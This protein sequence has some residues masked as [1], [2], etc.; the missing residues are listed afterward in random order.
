LFVCLFVFIHFFL[1]VFLF[2]LFKRWTPSRI[3]LGALNRRPR[4]LLLANIIE[5]WITVTFRLRCSDSMRNF[6]VTD[7]VQNPGTKLKW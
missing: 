1:F 7:I 6:L 3:L 5:W 4:L 2:Y